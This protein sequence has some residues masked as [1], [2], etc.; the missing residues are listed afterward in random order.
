M[1]KILQNFCTKIILSKDTYG[2]GKLE[3]LKGNKVVFDHLGMGVAETWR[4]I[5][6]GRLRG[7]LRMSA[8]CIPQDPGSNGTSVACEAKL[9]IDK[10]NI[11][12][13]L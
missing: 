3:E 7:L 8:G 13:K 5:S 6:D 10:R 12:P 9:K 11:C 1:I 2:T 4:G